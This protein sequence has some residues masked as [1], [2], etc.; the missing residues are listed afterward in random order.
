MYKHNMI[1]RNYKLD[2]NAG[3]L[4][5]I[6]AINYYKNDDKKEYDDLIKY[7]ETDCIVMFD[8][9]NYLRKQYN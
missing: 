9:I 5:I 8:I 6:S 1:K 2:C 4:S 3:D 7:N